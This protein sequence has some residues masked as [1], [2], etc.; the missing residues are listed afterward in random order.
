MSNFIKKFH[1]MTGHSEVGNFVYNLYKNHIKLEA[2]SV[3]QGEL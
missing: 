2:E 3:D 1:N